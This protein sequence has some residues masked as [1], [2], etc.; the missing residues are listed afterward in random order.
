MVRPDKILYGPIAWKNPG[1]IR[2][3][4]KLLIF[5][6]EAFRNSRIGETGQDSLWSHC[7][8]KSRKNPGNKKIINFHS[9]SVPE[10]PNVSQP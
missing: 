5:I 3:I 4:K 1:K 6:Q 10:F 9:G 7:S 2:E 8:E